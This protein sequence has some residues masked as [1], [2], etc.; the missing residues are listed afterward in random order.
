MKILVAQDALNA[1]GGV[2]SYLAS[3]IPALRSRGHSVALLFVRRQGGAPLV[4]EVDGPAVAVHSHSVDD[5]F[6]E[7]RAWGPDV[8]FSNNMMRLDVERRALDEWPVV[9]FMHGYF[10]TCV[11]ALKMHA[12]PFRIACSRTLGPACLALY[13]PRHC[14]A[15][16]PGALVG[17]YRW[18]RGQQRLFPR[19]AT[20]MVASDHMAEE[21]ARHGA[22]RDRIAMLPLFPSLTA[23][24]PITAPDNSVLFLGRMTD[25]KGGDLVIRAVSRAATKLKRSIPLVMA[26]DGPER[27]AWERLASHEN[28]DAEFPGWLDPDRRI[29]ALRRAWV[30]AVPSVWPEPFGLVGLEAAA[31]G[32]PAV[33]FDTGGIRQWL[34]HDISG[35][36]VP[37]AERHTGLAAALARV[38]DDH[39]LRNRLSLGALAT[40]RELSLDVHTRAL[41]R[42]LQQAAGRFRHHGTTA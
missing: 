14:G 33:A 42:L 39:G 32:V 40:A 27:R 10:G 34:R 23:S 7:L 35:L 9:K 24:A 22:P 5:A 29:G 17:G 19:Y 37:P 18:A 12:F 38:L 26:G 6:A 16:T 15:L 25:L 21:F 11:S 3:I 4:R 1:E 30:L 20:V 2:E 36:L 31:M 8:C 41:E 28:V 13:G